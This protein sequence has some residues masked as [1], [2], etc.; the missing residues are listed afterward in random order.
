MRGLGDALALDPDRAP[1]SSRSCAGVIDVADRDAAAES[2]INT[3]SPIGIVPDGCSTCSLETPLPGGAVRRECSIR[4]GPSDELRRRRDLLHTRAREHLETIEI[5]RP[6]A[7][8]GPPCRCTA[9]GNMAHHRARVPA[10][11]R[12]CPA[13]AV[14]RRRRRTQLRRALRAHA[15]RDA[16]NRW[17]SVDSPDRGGLP[18]PRRAAGS[19]PT[20]PGCRCVV[21]RRRYQ[22]QRAGGTPLH[23]GGASSGHR[24]S[25]ALRRPASCRR[26][27]D[28]IAGRG[29]AP[30][31]EHRRDPEPRLPIDAG[32]H[33][34][35]RQGDPGPFSPAT[36][37]A[38][39]RRW[40]Q[41]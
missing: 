8:C 27:C 38:D 31:R 12:S 16:M 32:H 21:H 22:A 18:L 37:P 33:D 36:I 3:A 6:A 40:C 17:T 24:G 19:P 14:A 5:S 11:A 34:A 4:D 7:V 29:I 28:D 35:R 39:A 26:S 41:G 13:L 25:P 23:D 1:I 9:S 10:A 2:T 20:V 15:P 30:P